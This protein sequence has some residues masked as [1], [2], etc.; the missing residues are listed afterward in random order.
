MSRT[1]KKTTTAPA[2]KPAQSTDDRT[3]IADLGR[4][5]LSLAEETK[6][7]HLQLAAVGKSLEGITSELSAQ[8]SRMDRLEGKLDML[9]EHITTPEPQNMV[10][11]FVGDLL[12]K[13]DERAATDEDSEAIFRK[14]ADIERWIEAN[15][16]A[17]EATA[18]MV[19]TATEQFADGIR[20]AVTSVESQFTSFE[21]SQAEKTEFQAAAFEKA[22]GE[23]VQRFHSQ[24]SDWG[25]A[26]TR[27][28]DEARVFSEAGA[29][30]QAEVSNLSK[31]HDEFAEIGRS[32][33]SLED[34]LARTD[35]TRIDDTL[36][37]SRLVQDLHNQ[38]AEWSA[39][40]KSWSNVAQSITSETHALAGASDRV[41]SEAAALSE[42]RRQVQEMQAALSA[43]KDNMPGVDQS[44]MDDA[45]AL[46]TL[47]Q[48]L[49]DQKAEWSA[50]VKSW[51][52]ITKSAI[53]ETQTLNGAGAQVA[54]EVQA[55][56]RARQEF[57]TTSDALHT[58]QQSMAERDGGYGDG[59]MALNE[60]LQE[61]KGQ[62]SQWG[63][64]LQSWSTVMKKVSNETASLSQTGDRMAHE[65]AA[66]A[67]ARQ[68]VEELGAT[69]QQANTAELSQAE[70]A[71]ALAEQIAAIEP[72]I[73][74]T[75]IKVIENDP[76]ISDFQPS[77]SA[78]F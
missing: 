6:T 43:L 36:A 56:A 11:R 12:Q 59:T 73:V 29:Q 24:T 16:K 50:V 53:V 26:V 23:V 17:E 49:Y 14:L 32:L 7:G 37:L 64:L 67:N 75:L 61:M 35:K 19:R 51:S 52:S 70:A 10:E 9:L 4:A 60:A 72:T 20:S 1:E 30:M 48:E 3:A 77:P 68:L 57:E 66:F 44:E 13:L 41:V 62:R 63:A 34:N 28:A 65:V 69:P 45:L 31:A 2:A 39:L 25:A 40:V 15:Q 8:Q 47:I 5:A 27:V 46:R 76:Q 54:S 78:S 38:K 55:I 21:A 33:L 71:K 22:M 74:Q 18:E 58:L 42:A